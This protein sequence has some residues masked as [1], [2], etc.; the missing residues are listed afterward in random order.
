VGVSSFLPPYGFQRLNSSFQAGQEVLLCGE[1]FVGP[2]QVHFLHA[3]LY[4]NISTIKGI[5][6]V[7]MLLL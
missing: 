2:R 1:S 4:T 5:P 3:I 7:L 6:Q